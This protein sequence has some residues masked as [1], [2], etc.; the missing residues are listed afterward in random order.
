MPHLIDNLVN[1]G[2]DN[3]WERS[4]K[5]KFF[6]P[7]VNSLSKRWRYPMKLEFLV[8]KSKRSVDSKISVELIFGTNLDLKVRWFSKRKKKDFGKLEEKL[9]KINQKSELSGKY[10]KIA[11]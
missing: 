4:Y 7:I 11:K 10:S 3:E 2:N 8:Q 5:L 1:S 6:V 9:S